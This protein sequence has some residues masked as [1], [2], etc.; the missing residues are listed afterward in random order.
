MRFKSLPTYRDQVASIARNTRTNDK[1]PIW[2]L[3]IRLSFVSRWPD[4]PPMADS[5]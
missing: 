5:R 2:A 1:N 4:L 3:N